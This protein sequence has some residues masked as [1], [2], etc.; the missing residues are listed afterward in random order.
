MTIARALSS[1]VIAVAIASSPLP[2]AA[3]TSPDEP[4]AL[5]VYPYVAVDTANGTDTLIQLGN[6]ASGPV[7]LRCFYENLTPLCIN[8]QA[9]ERCGP[10]PVT[11]SGACEPS[12]SRV[13]MRIRVT[14]RQPL[15][16]SVSAGLQNLPLDGVTRIGPAGQSNQSSEIPG[17]GGGPFVG[18]LRCV[19][20]SSDMFRPAPDNVLFGQAT[21]VRR[22]GA[23]EAFDDDAEYRA[24]G[25]KATASTISRDEFLNLGGPSA[26]YAA[27]PDVVE[28]E[29][30][31]DGA[32]TLPGSI[33][34]QAAT[35]LALTNCTNTILSSMNVAQFLVFNE[36]AQRF[37]TSTQIGFQLVKPLSKIDTS[38]E[39]HSIFSSAINGTLTGRTNIHGAL[40]GLHAVAIESHGDPTTPY[41]MHSDAAELHGAGVRLAGDVLTYRLPQCTAD[42]NLDGKVSIDETV[43]AVNIGLGNTSPDACP[44]ADRDGDAK[45]TVDELVAAVDSALNG[46]PD[47]QS[48]PTPEVTPVPTAT[49]TRSPQSVGPEITHFGIATADD[50]P[51]AAD[52]T[53]AMGRPIYVH[54]FGQGM[55]LIVEARRGQSDS[56][57][58]TSTYSETG[59]LPDLQVL[60]SRPLGDGIADVCEDDGHSGGVPAIPTLDFQSDAAA[61]AINDLGCRAYGRQPT[62]CTRKLGVPT[63]VG[64]VQGFATVDSTSQVQFCI[65]IAKAWA[66]PV[67][68][69]I[70]AARVRDQA[71]N[72]GPEQKIV[73]RVGE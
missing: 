71:G 28:F 56:P 5:L 38:L 27:C 7:D 48:P 13:P 24:I 53:D 15:A 58:A 6:V 41:E 35:T 73:V 39:S 40:G 10:G 22:R 72:L 18:T 42:C 63:G 62:V 45:V 57:V 52:S 26:E 49:P 8:G 33:T 30:F 44:P 19:V 9:G 32:S 12:V 70:V 11:C 2:S 1:F 59:Q 31:F 65:P 17:V 4:A 21:I 23:P 67:G 51:L 54:L 20:V 64:S 43:L 3:Q 60:V 47:P 61:A 14:A 68:D 37:T 66:F 34:P 36:F 29:H 55:T 25:V 46:C 50:R 69:T 16:W